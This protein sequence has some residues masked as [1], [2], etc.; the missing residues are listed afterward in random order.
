MATKEE[1]AALA[2]VI[3]NDQRGGGNDSILNTLRLP[4]GWQDLSRLGF[5][6][7]DNLNSNPVSFTAGAYLNS[8]T[9][10]IVV[11][12]KGTDFLIEFNGRGWATT[13]DLIADVALALSRKAFGIQNVQQMLASSYFLAVVDWASQ[14]NIDPSKI[15]FTGHSLGGGLA[16][17]M[18][19]WFG[20]IKGKIKGSDSI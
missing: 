6:P 8:A 3:Y 16:S 11:S 20:K 19:A 10:E 5:T 15:S 9:G 17:N 7:G 1:Y 12:Y 2:A 14:N 13:A 18:A 4:P